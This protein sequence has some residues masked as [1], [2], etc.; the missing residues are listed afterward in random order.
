M[1]HEPVA[2]RRPSGPFLQESFFVETRAI[3]GYSGSPVWV[4]IPP[5]SMRIKPFDTKGKALGP[6]ILGVDWSHINDY[7]P[8][9]DRS[10]NPL[11]FEIVANT[12]VMGVVPAWKLHELLYMKGPVDMR[13]DIEDKFQP[14]SEAVT[15]T[16]LSGEKAASPAS[17]ANIL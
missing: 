11:P 17:D 15:K 16:S 8:A 12:G 13:K 7:M 14:P 10:G 9:R 5:T 6:W 4:Y 3:P 1:P 2:T